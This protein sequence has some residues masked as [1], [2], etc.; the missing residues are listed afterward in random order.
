MATTLELKLREQGD[1]FSMSM[2]RLVS[3]VDQPELEAK[4]SLWTF[5][6]NIADVELEV[7]DKIFLSQ[8]I[9]W[10]P[11]DDAGRQKGLPLIEQ[12]RW[13]TLAQKVNE[14]DDEKEGEIVLSNKDIELIWDRM[15]L[16]EFKVFALTPPYIAFLLN[17]Q[18][19]T[20]RWFPELEPDVEKHV[21]LLKTTI[22][23]Q[24]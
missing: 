10:V 11:V 19:T 18:E 4:Q 8:I 2:R 15:K 17:F 1:D 13:I 12:V 14:I 23:K 3:L 16:R 5:F 7:H 6:K 22:H 21:S 20:N 24:L 9:N